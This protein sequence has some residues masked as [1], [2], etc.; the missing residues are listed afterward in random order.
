MGYPWQVE[1]RSLVYS[2]IIAVVDWEDHIPLRGCL[3][4]ASAMLG[5]E[6]LYCEALS[7]SISCLRAFTAILACC[8]P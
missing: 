1:K 8:L 5:S 2:N 7:A 4:R 6:S 3:Q